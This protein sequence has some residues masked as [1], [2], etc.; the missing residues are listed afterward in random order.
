MDRIQ[1]KWGASVNFT[2]NDDERVG[3]AFWT[4]VNRFWLIEAKDP[5]DKSLSI[6]NVC[7]AFV[8]STMYCNDA[9]LCIE[10]GIATE[11]KHD[12]LSLILDNNPSVDLIN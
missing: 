6:E 2:N 9:E 12:K 10:N 4:Q 7:I 5:D 3:F 8:K 1:Y 11:I